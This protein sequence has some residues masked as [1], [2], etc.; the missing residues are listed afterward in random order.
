MS[1]D[2]LSPAESARTARQQIL[3]ELG[4]DGQLKLKTATVAVVG[5]GGL[6]S[7]VIEYLAAAGVGR[8]VIID[9]DVVEE[10]NLHRQRLHSHDDLHRPK[11]SSAFAA[12][13]RLAPECEVVEARTRLTRANAVDLLRD[14]DVII[15]GSDSFETRFDVNFAARVLGLPVVW[16]AVLRWDAQVTVFWPSPPGGISAVDLTDAFADTKETR[17]TVSCSTAGVI[18]PVC[19]IA[20]SLMALETIKLITSIGAPLLGRMQVI[21]GLSA[22]V[23]QVAILP[24]QHDVPVSISALTSIPD[25][26]LVVD[27][28]KQSERDV[29]PGPLESLHFPL[30]QLLQLQEHSEAPMGKDTGIVVVC[31]EGPRSA[32]AARHLIRIGYNVLGFLDGGVNAKH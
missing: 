26:A 8:L 22:E 12:V 21:N 31:A 10:S 32:R 13:Q 4:L 16:G 2:A 18:G 11:T 1:P 24:Q 5:A 23:T 9:D 17:E 30:D 28:R 20:G 19:G 7:P 27:V 6:G 3:P 29:L 15:D 25:T 14:A